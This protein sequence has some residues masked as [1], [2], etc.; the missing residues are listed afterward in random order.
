[1]IFM[2]I[3]KIT[4]AIK[5]YTFSLIL[6][7]SIII[8]G[9]VGITFGEEVTFLKPL[10][11]IFIN[12]MFTVLIPL[13]FF[14]LASS[15]A[16]IKSSK[17]F[18]KIVMSIILAFLFMSL[19]AAIY[20]LIITAFFPPGQG[21]TLK[22]A[23]PALSSIN[24][25]PEEHSFL[26]L[27]TVSDFSTLFTR[28]SMLALMVFAVVMGCAVS[29]TG[30]AAQPFV[31]F[32]N[33]GMAVFMKMTTFVMYYA[34]IGF[35]AYFAVLVG[36]MGS[37]IVGSYVRIAVIYYCAAIVYFAVGYTFFA[38]IAGKR[39]G[40]KI[41]WKY[42]LPP[43]IT[44]FATCSS[45]ASMP[46]SLEAAEK[47]EID[48]KIYKMVIPLGTIIHKQ[49]SIIGGIVKISFLFSFFHLPFS[50]V[51]TLFTAV[52]VA[53]LVGTV[54]GAIPSGGML[55]EMLIIS[56]YGFP[57]ETLMLIAVISLIIDPPATMLNVTG[58]TVASMLVDRWRNLFQR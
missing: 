55:G 11:E 47:M 22:T 32:L 39:N 26:S 48:S 42:A 4:K 41:L 45:A 40:I 33:A 52:M 44:G 54:M 20:M 49:G 43:S 14:S 5:S 36:S 13:I 7:L 53:I 30:K 8:G 46:V 21:F 18:G 9:I 50:D 1:M 23:L 56:V 16:S 31:D 27:L 35:F 6:L 38:W 17:Q 24:S 57:A 12:L 29:V 37:Q 3:L 15:V 2:K 34:P 19:I 51:H 28:Q 10:G 58:N 25:A